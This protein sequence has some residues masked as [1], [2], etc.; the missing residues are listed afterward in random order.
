[1]AWHG[2]V[3][4]FLQKLEFSMLFTTF[5]DK[6]VFDFLDSALA[7]TTYLPCYFTMVSYDDLIYYN[8]FW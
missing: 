3:D 4:L 1:M 8:S 7:V 5:S 2:I 6:T